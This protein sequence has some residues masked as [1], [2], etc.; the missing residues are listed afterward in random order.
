[1]DNWIKILLCNY[2]LNFD[3]NKKALLQ[4]KDI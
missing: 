2:K 3:E 1:M 4:M